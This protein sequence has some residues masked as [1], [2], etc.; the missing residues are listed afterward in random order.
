MGV[1]EVMAL[2]PTSGF[3][4]DANSSSPAALTW[5]ADT[6]SFGGLAGRLA[7]DATHPEATLTSIGNGNP[8]PYFGC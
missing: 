8:N 3:S 6:G 4:S 5:W 2:T 7:V 1:D